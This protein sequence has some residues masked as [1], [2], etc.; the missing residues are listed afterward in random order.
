M[1]IN[2]KI[3][4]CNRFEFGKFLFGLLFCTSVLINSCHQKNGEFNTGFFAKEDTIAIIQTALE[5]VK[6]DSIFQLAFPG[7]KLKL[8]RNDIVKSDYDIMFRGQHTLIVS[9]DS[10]YYY[11]SDDPKA[12]RFF[13]VV[14]L[15]KRISTN[16][17]RVVLVF[18]GIG[19]TADFLVDR[20]DNKW[21]ISKR[22]I[23]RI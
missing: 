3:F 21:I 6:L 12:A 23:G 8:V 10:S 16:Q 18:Y 20:V 17:A 11:F 19:V 2:Y 4:L 13:G 1:M 5:D 14:N 7:R 22:I 15:F 9:Y